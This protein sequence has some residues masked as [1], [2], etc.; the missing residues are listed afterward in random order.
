MATALEQ[1]E[2]TY[3]LWIRSTKTEMVIPDDAEVK[4]AMALMQPV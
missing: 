1:M 2:N 4:K 3:N